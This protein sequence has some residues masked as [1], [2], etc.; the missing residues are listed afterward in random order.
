MPNASILL[1]DKENSASTRKL[2][3]KIRNYEYTYQPGKINYYSNDYDE[4]NVFSWAY[5]IKSLSERKEE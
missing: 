4:S 2:M 3:A 5:L 1:T